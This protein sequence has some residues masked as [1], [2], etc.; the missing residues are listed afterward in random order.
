MQALQ[1]CGLWVLP[2]R[3]ARL[4]KR[5]MQ[6][7]TRI[8][9]NKVAG[10]VQMDDSVVLKDIVNPHF[11]P[12]NPAPFAQTPPPGETA[13]E[14]R[15]RKIAHKKAKKLM[16]QRQYQAKLALAASESDLKGAN[17]LETI[18]LCTCNLDG[19][20][21]EST[22][23]DS[24][25]SITTN[26]SAS[27]NGATSTANTNTNDVCAASAVSISPA[28][29]IHSAKLILCSTCGGC[30]PDSLALSAPNR[31]QVAERLRKSHNKRIG[32]PGYE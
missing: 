26:G 17:S 2:S 15:A 19:K 1:I 23:S 22:L 30:P 18:P 5:A 16:K 7:G 29:T 3:C 28:N 25:V 11:L 21:Q 9:N 14:K 20:L 27:A 12:E 31:P 4:V 32:R 10:Y 6:F 24:P 13:E 8:A